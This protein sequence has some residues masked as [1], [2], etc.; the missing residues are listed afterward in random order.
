MSTA[1]T[2]APPR[3]VFTPDDAQDVADFLAAEDRERFRWACWL[4]AKRAVLRSLGQA[5]AWAARMIERYH[6][7]GAI[8][9]V[10]RT[11]G[12]LASGVRL[13][14]Q[15]LQVVGVSTAVGWAVSSPTVRRAVSTAAAT[16]VSVARNLGSWLGGLVRAG[17][18]LFGSSGR[19]L[20][21]RLGAAV[22][23]TTTRVADAVRPVVTALK[24]ALD[25]DSLHMQ[26]LATLAR[27]RAV[28]RL[29]SHF[30]PRPW[31]T[32]ARIVAGLL[33]LPKVVRDELSRIVLETPTRVVRP[34]TPARATASSSTP[35][36]AARATGRPAPASSTGPMSKP[37]ATTA[38]QSNPAVE[39]EVDVDWTALA[40]EVEAEAKTSG[41]RYPASKNRA[42]RR[43]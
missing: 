29:L 20:A 7:G 18:S 19:A 39:G 15:G 33:M 28:G 4:M 13:V 9:M 25:V 2:Y 30:L 42:A 41:S 43:R 17:L 21:D 8:V 16:V 27:G 14:R 23:R 37:A 40:E 10:R 36:S 11:M 32:L 38:G 26:A 34:T 6:L 22:T 31:G 12:W 3:R 5:R 35:G 24:V 1:T